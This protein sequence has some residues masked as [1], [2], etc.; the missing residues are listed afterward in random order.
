M[1]KT[2]DDLEA[3]R[4]VTDALIGFSPEDQER[5]IRWAREKLGLATTPRNL[6]DTRIPQPSSL[7]LPT[8]P[9]EPIETTQPPPSARDLKT[10]VTGKSPKNDVQFAATVAYFYRF[11]APPEQR[12]SEIDPRILQDACRLASRERFKYP[13]TTL[14]NAKNLGLLD[15]GSKRGQ[16]A[17]NSVGENLVAMTLPAQSDNSTTRTKPKKPNKPRKKTTQRKMTRKKQ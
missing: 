8:R 13:L 7:A 4:A 16:F 2:T 9:T 12:L 10:F 1:A 14:N 11:E 3:V 15:S 5:I 17:I 6:P